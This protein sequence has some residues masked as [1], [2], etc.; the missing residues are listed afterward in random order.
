MKNQ[1]LARIEEN[2]AS[3]LKNDIDYAKDRELVQLSDP[4]ITTENLL[5]GETNAYLGEA[6]HAVIEMERREGRNISMLSEAAAGQMTIAYQNADEEV[7]AQ[8]ARNVRTSFGDNYEKVFDQLGAHGMTAIERTKAKIFANVKPSIAVAVSKGLSGLSHHPGKDLIDEKELYAEF[9]TL[10]AGLFGAGDSERQRDMYNATKGLAF[11]LAGDDPTQIK[12]FLAEGANGVFGGIG[13]YSD[14]GVEMPNADVNIVS[15]KTD[16]EVLNANDFTRKGYVPVDTY[17]TPHRVLRGVQTGALRM[18]RVAPNTYRF[19]NDMGH[20]IQTKTKEGMKTYE[21]KYQNQYTNEQA[22]TD[23]RR[24]TGADIKLGSSS[25]PLDPGYFAR[26][27]KARKVTLKAEVN[28]A[29]KLLGNDLR[30]KR[31]GNKGA[32]EF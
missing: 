30:Q 11:T 22:A 29:N 24:E 12:D 19:V 15:F 10:T 27:Q 1:F 7:K 25:L 4:D 3:Y 6:R 21:W 20:A 17:W 5:S 9:A 13:V 2:R 14:F 16:M 18:Q 31:T 8:F 32:F 28:V 26:L 23:H